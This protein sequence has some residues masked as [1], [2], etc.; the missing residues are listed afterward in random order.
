MV[1]ANMSSNNAYGR[2]LIGSGSGSGRSALATSASTSARGSAISHSHQVVKY[3]KAPQAPRRFKS[4]Y[5][6]FST[7]KHKEIRAEL[8]A[9]AAPAPA[10]NNNNNDDDDDDEEEGGDDEEG[11]GSGSGAKV[12]YYIG[13]CI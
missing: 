2:R 5:M 8:T 7:K 3:K 11:R 13:I 6:F 10:K 1:M 12:S 4:S 9:A